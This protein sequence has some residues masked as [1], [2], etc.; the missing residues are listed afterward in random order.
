MIFTFKGMRGSASGYVNKQR[1]RWENDFAPF[2]SL[3]VIS[4]DD[5]RKNL[6]TSVS[7][8]AIWSK[9]DKVKATQIFYFLNFQSSNE[10]E[11]SHFLTSTGI[12]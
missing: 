10:K 4:I 5:W 7:A 1:T 8:A 6:G 11:R 12:R 2:G 9:F 3:F